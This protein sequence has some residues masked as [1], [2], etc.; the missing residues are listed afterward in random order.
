M[1]VNEKEM[2]TLESKKFQGEL[3]LPACKPGPRQ[4]REALQRDLKT[5]GAFHGR[6]LGRFTAPF[7]LQQQTLRDAAPPHPLYFFSLDA[8]GDHAK[9]HQHHI[10]V[11]T[12]EFGVI[13]G[14]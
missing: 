11:I 4:A 7:C 13:C 10:G 1:P 8:V 2:K 14:S 12:G 5:I 6:T 3:V 9:D